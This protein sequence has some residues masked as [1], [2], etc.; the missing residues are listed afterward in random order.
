M[1]PSVGI[2]LGTTYS[3]VA[4]IA[5]D[6]RPRTVHNAEGKYLTPSVVLFDESSHVVG[7]E[8]KLAAPLLPDRIADFAKRDVGNEFY[9]RKIDGQQVRPEEVQALILEKVKCDAERVVGPFDAAVITVPAFYNDVRRKS[10]QDAGQLAGL[11]VLDII[12]EPT[13]AGLVYGVDCGFM[14]S[15]GCSKSLERILVYDLG[16][17]TFDCTLMEIDTE[18]CRVLATEGEVRLGGIDWDQ[19][20]ANHIA[21]Q[22]SREHRG[23]DVRD[24]PAGHQRLLAEA[25]RV[26]LALSAREQTMAVFEHAGNALRLSILRDELERMTEELIERTVRCAE[27][28]IESQNFQWS[29][30][31]RVL[32]VGG[33]T[34][35]PAVRRRLEQLSS[36][37]VDSL[38]SPD[39][40]VAQGAAL[41]AEAILLERQ[42]PTKSDA[43]SASASVAAAAPARRVSRF[44]DVCSHDLGVIARDR[45]RKQL[46]YSR[47]L[48]KNTPL[49]ASQEKSYR[50]SIESQR[51]L[52]VK[53]VEGS[54]VSHDGDSLLISLNRDSAVDIEE[55]TRLIQVFDVALPA[56]LPQGTRIFVAIEVQTNG[57]IAVVVRVPD[58]GITSRNEVSH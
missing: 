20:L 17:G 58:A 38:L 22:F 41:H 2:D 6:G 18:G 50:T 32:L 24:D 9:H 43:G 46:T 44:R 23:I 7:D 12:N 8:A 31:T 42:G 15:S 29:D 52:A 28:A 55:M 40:A 53:L 13:A 25:E 48:A 14:D 27:D 39:E 1:P 45:K 16:G 54:E 56:G 19:R 30:L 21:E 35:M 34:R 26:K 47:I 4:H 37:P 49:P 36:I 5:A 33:A 51:R 11:D 57:R 10:T 3:V